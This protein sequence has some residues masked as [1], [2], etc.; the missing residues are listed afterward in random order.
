MTQ[1]IEH[2]GSTAGGVEKLGVM[3]VVP[4]IGRTVF[5]SLA[6]PMAVCDEATQF[7]VQTIR[8]TGAPTGQPPQ[9]GW[10]RDSEPDWA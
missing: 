6:E 1:A 2:L 7:P 8:P 9:T 5:E 4:S 3:R 10:D